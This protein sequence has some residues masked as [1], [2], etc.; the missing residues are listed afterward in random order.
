MDVESLRSVVTLADEL[1]F[2]RA[3]RR[4]FVSEAPFG[5][6]I[7]RVEAAVGGK[8]FE[9]TSRR[10]GLTPYGEVVVARIRAVL[11]GLD[12]LRPSPH[13]GAAVRVGV[14]GFGVGRSWHR[15]RRLALGEVADV[16]L[17]HR[18]LSLA[19]QYSALRHD[20]VD[21]ALVHH[22]GD[23]DGLDLIPVMRT[24]RVA[25]VPR[26]STYSSADHLGVDDVRPGSWLAFEGVDDRFADWVGS[27]GGGRVTTTLDTLVTAVA[28]T[29]LLGVHGAVASEFYAR[30]DVVFVPLEGAPVTT[31]LAVRCDDHRPAIDAF[32][33]AAHQVSEVPAA[34]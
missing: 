2:G 9:R 24:P 22:L 20:E 16:A 5:R 3:A 21:V 15:L 4:H 17:V 8:I 19:D 11:A 1:H 23:V 14:L 34:S 6:R 10:V 33:R 27:T 28:T 18:P 29:G 26:D 32:R 30:P 7:R 12:T 25:V 13:D 31:A